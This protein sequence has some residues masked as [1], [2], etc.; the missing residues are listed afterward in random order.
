MNVKMMKPEYSHLGGQIF[1]S[2]LCV[3]GRLEAKYANFKEDEY[4]SRI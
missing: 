3:S 4:K 2:S 1:V